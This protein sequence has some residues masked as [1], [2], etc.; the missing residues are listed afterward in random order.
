VQVAE[1]EALEKIRSEVKLSEIHQKACQKQIA[2][3]EQNCVE[4][5]SKLLKMQGDVE[6][7]AA[8]SVSNLSYCSM[9]TVVI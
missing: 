4:L 8:K 2:V 1:I 3:E 5:E 6:G 9:R 7:S